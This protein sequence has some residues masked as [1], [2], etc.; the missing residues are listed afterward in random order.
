MREITRVVAA[1]VGLAFV[2][3]F[4]TVIAF[5]FDLGIPFIGALFLFVSVF[6]VLQD[7]IG[8]DGD[9]SGE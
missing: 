6:V 9:A 7:R 1:A 8:D 2:L 3:P 4:A 5:R